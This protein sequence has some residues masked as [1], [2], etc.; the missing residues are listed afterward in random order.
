MLMSQNSPQDV[1]RQMAVDIRGQ[2]VSSYLP[3]GAVD[4]SK[5]DLPNKHLQK[6]GPSPFGCGI[7]T[8]YLS[9]SV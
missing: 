4:A 5:F 1:P 3:T 8:A 7:A 9:S 2:E 6:K